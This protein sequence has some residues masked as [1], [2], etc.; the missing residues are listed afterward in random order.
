[1]F[2]I[3]SG[4]WGRLPWCTA[5]VAFIRLSWTWR[6]LHLLIPTMKSG[7]LSL[8]RP[9]LYHRL[10]IESI[11]GEMTSD[12]GKFFEFVVRR[13]RHAKSFPTLAP[14]WRIINTA[15]TGHDSL[16]FSTCIIWLMERYRLSGR[17][18]FMMI[19][20]KE[21]KHSSPAAPVRYHAMTSILSSLLHFCRSGKIQLEEFKKLRSPTYSLSM[22][23]PH[24][25]ANRPTR[26]N[27]VRDDDR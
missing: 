21:V 20:R 4:K 19:Q 12:W 6:H 22:P 27:V 10:I 26:E 17:K 2:N 14:E 16:F 11:R 7:Y 13:Q 25:L 9:W 5:S 24:A 1:M 3:T 8:L 15:T 23:G 18:P